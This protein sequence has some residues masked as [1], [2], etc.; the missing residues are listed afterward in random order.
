MPIA[1][2]NALA[3]AIALGLMASA[4]VAPRVETSAAP[5][6]QADAATLADLEAARDAV[7]A[8]MA[9]PLGGGASVDEAFA[10]LRMQAAAARTPA[11]HLH[12]LEAFVFALAD[13]H[14]ELS[15][16]NDYSPRLA[17]SGSSV[18]AD[19]RDGRWVITQVRLGSAARAA[20]LRE[21][22]TIDQINGAPPTTLALPPHTPDGEAYAAGFAMRVALAGTHVEDAV[23]VATGDQG[24]V[25]ARLPL[26]EEHNEELASLSY[27]A[28][29]I[30]LIRLHNSLGE[31]ALP[32]RFDALMSRARAARVVMLD[33]RDTPSGGDSDIAKP[34]M[35]W[36][37]Q[38]ERGYQRHRR[39]AREWT[40]TVKGRRDA[41]SGELIVLVDHW[42]GSMGEGMAIG[43]R[44]AAAATMVGTPMAGLRGA[45]ESF[46]LPC[47]RGVSL[48]LPVEQLFTTQ[49]R[50]RELAQPDVLVSEAALAAAGED[51][52]IMTA[53]LRRASWER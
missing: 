37:V 6:C 20:G 3:M 50:P 48:R 32:A 21:G 26:R 27:P 15:T 25:E 17:P 23:V 7:R 52:A 4:C 1:S 44:A 30:A 11:E 51:D 16:N 31:Q 40:E 33:L 47:L 34:I 12:V 18:W 35:S 41:F 53:A 29:D 22:M 9:Y 45:V 5:Q 24:S 14:I 8:H 46:P 13:H 2:Q 36:F 19:Y 39:G 28:P 49:G 42:T 43:L 10:P 38:G